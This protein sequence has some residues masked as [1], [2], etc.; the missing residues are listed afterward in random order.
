MD[1]EDDGE[2]IVYVPRRRFDRQRFDDQETGK[3][4]DD[5]IMAAAVCLKRRRHQS[6]NDGLLVAHMTAYAEEHLDEAGAHAHEM[7]S[8]VR[9]ATKT[10]R[11]TLRDGGAQ[12]FAVASHDE[13]HDGDEAAAQAHATERSSS[14][15]DD[16][17]FAA[18][19]FVD[20]EAA[21][22]AHE[23]KSAPSSI[24]DDNH[25]DDEAADDEAAARAHEPEVLSRNTDRD[26]ANDALPRTVEAEGARREDES[27]AIHHERSLYELQIEKHKAACDALRDEL[28]LAVQCGDSDGIANAFTGASDLLAY[29]NEASVMTV[30]ACCV[31]VCTCWSISLYSRPSYSPELEP[32]L[33]DGL[34]DTISQ[35]H[36]SKIGE[37]DPKQRRPI[38]NKMK[39]FLGILLCVGGKRSVGF[40]TRALG[41]PVTEDTVA[42][43]RQQ[44]PK[45][46]MGTSD[47]IIGNNLDNVVLPLLERFGL[48]DCM[49][50]LCEDGTSNQLRLDIVVEDSTKAAYGING[51]P[52]E[53]E[54]LGQLA[55]ALRERGL[56]STLYVLSIVPQVAGAPAI[57]VIVEANPNDFTRADV[58]RMHRSLFRHLKFRGLG[59]RICLGVSDGD[60][61]FRSQQLVLHFHDRFPGVRYLECDHPFIQLFAAWIKG[62]G[63]YI[64]TSDWMHIGWRL[65]RIFLCPD[66]ELLL[67]D[68]HI[69][70]GLMDV[71]SL[72]LHGDD[73]KYS[74]KQHWAGLLRMAGID[75]DGNVSSDILERLKTTS[76]ASFMYWKFVR[77]FLR[78][79]LCADEPIEIKLRWCG[80]V[81]GFVAL[82]R[83]LI[84]H[85]NGR[86][87]LTN[88]FLTDQSCVDVCVAMN[89]FVLLVDI[90]HTAAVTEDAEVKAQLQSLAVRLVTRMLSS[91]FSEYL[92]QFCRAE[93]GNATTFGAYVGLMHVNHFAWFLGLEHDL[94]NDEL[95]LSRR[96]APRGDSRMR[97]GVGTIERIQQLTQAN[98][99]GMIDQGIAECL[100]DYAE[101]LRQRGAGSDGNSAYAAPTLEQLKRQ[102]IIP[103]SKRKRILVSELTIELADE[104]SSASPDEK[105]G[106]GSR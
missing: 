96:G 10:S 63:F 53:V 95:P 75:D 87:N 51:G 16:A 1:G 77:L 31:L 103:E 84:K 5:E 54:S 105:V 68:F 49:M 69:H 19:D 79:F 92:F 23:N 64:Q 4:E 15:P 86:R 73:L 43:R 28:R 98:R 41:N 88:N 32:T 65:R 14:A 9:R 82:W 40:V 56:A 100:S 44:A 52:F 91:R 101:A 57:P 48:L 12:N 42:G 70:A 74:E 46:M 7:L 26:D 36:L 67:G 2:A 60:S 72:G 59:G 17:R 66:R 93:H 38:G 55:Q 25:V 20:D 58:W 81:L 6:P 18:D 94:E 29:E 30:V 106:G 61:R 35:F 45:L 22:F 102:P 27:A 62:H 37:D 104:E 34:F 89:G 21:A 24:P 90:L 97:W 85:S 99:N 39:A 11:S 78:V 47:Q 13:E 76:C 50:E 80:Y 8:V 71:A 33:T 3:L 83:Y